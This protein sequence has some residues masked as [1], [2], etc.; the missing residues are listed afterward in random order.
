VK[1]I[2]AARSGSLDIAL[3][4]ETLGLLE[5]ALDQRDLLPQLE[6]LLAGGR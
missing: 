1:A 6:A 2:L 5:S 3:M 4:R